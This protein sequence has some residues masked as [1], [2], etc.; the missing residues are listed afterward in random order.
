MGSAGPAAAVGADLRAQRPGV[1][2]VGVEQRLV[3]G[4]HVAALLRLG[5]R[6]GSLVQP[7][8]RRPPCRA[9]LFET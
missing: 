6:G 8:S 1:R 9:R 7:P 2:A 5:E 4:Q 3:A